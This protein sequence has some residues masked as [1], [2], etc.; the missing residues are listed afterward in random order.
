M[1]LF[2]GCDGSSQGKVGDYF[3]MSSVWADL[4]LGLILTLSLH[5]Y[6]EGL[7]GQAGHV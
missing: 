1:K 5:V 4:D 7:H 2:E 3:Q 6:A